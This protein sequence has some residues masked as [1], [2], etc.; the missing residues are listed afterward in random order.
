MLPCF[1][2]GVSKADSS[3]KLLSLE[4]IR[5]DSKQ[6]YL[7]VSPILL[8]G[9][10]ALYTAL[11]LLKLNSAG[12]ESSLWKVFIPPNSRGSSALAFVFPASSTFSM[13][14]ANQKHWVGPS[15]LQNA[16]AS[17]TEPQA[18]SCQA[19]QRVKSWVLCQRTRTTCK[20]IMAATGIKMWEGTQ[21]LR[22][23]WIPVIS[24]EAW[25]TGCQDPVSTERLLKIRSEKANQNSGHKLQL[26]SFWNL[27]SILHNLLVN[28]LLFLQTPWVKFAAY[29]D[30]RSS[31]GIIGKDLPKP[32]ISQCLSARIRGLNQYKQAKHK[33][34]T[35]HQNERRKR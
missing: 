25:V 21:I 15:P 10:H 4:T 33:G 24:W 17:P 5:N 26:Y 11:R 35:S 31:R 16:E 12:S 34:C 13:G 1:R 7:K 22:G 3:I 14:M 8:D 29:S 6:V 9:A 20:D 18:A 28:H 32:L 23:T 19:E 2:R 27:V 30:E